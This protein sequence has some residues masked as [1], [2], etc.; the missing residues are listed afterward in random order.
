[1]S[2]KIKYAYTCSRGRVRKNNEDNFWVLGSYLEK[3][4]GGMATIVEGETEK[5]AVPAFAVFD[6]MG[7]E[8]CGETAA[9]LAADVFDECYQEE[10]GDCRDYVEEFL[11]ETCQK[12][13]QAV[14]DYARENR[15]SCMGSTAAMMLF[16]RNRIGV[17]NVGDS[18]IYQI[19]EDHFR[20]ISQ[21]HVAHLQNYRKAPLTQYIGLPQEEVRLMPYTVSGTYHDGDRFLL[22]TDGLTDMLS[23]QE[24]WQIVD[25]YEEVKDAVFYLLQAAME[26]GGRDNTTMILCELVE[27]KSGKWYERF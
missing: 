22:C 20:Q 5:K 18:R 10:N 9:F 16:G 21:D 4:N 13:N 15:I 25:S 27:E 23:D 14:C 7:G 26:R 11:Q 17:C 24:I 12:M 3:I 8:S 6:G 1:M 2:Y 19:Y